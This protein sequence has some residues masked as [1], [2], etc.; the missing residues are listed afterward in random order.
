LEGK[1][2][3]VFGSMILTFIACWFSYYLDGL[4]Q[5][6]NLPLPY[7]PEWARAF[8]MF[9]RFGS[10]ILNPLLY[11]FFKEDFKRALFASFGSSERRST[12]LTTVN[13]TPV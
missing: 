9:L 6:L 4:M 8:L 5:D 12:R 2:V 13:T 10:S 3:I 11:T 7:L 1:A